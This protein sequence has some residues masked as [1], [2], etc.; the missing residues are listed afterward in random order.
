M[1]KLKLTESNNDYLREY[2]TTGYQND[3][4]GSGVDLVC[5][6]TLTFEG[7]SLG[8][9][10]KFN[11]S[12]QP[13]NPHGYWLLPRSS[14]SKTPLRMSNSLGLIDMDYRGEI[15]AK[16]DNLSNQSYVIEKGTKLFQLALPS[17]VPCTIELVE[18]LTET[19]RGEG[20]FGST[21]TT[22]SAPLVEEV[23]RSANC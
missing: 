8:N 12:C 13:E 16:V 11:I 5:P 17:L 22:Y 14:I 2:Y 4:L 23:R 9:K 19:K 6:E 10:I 21:G 7:H 1:L 15:M 18:E 3:T 20:G